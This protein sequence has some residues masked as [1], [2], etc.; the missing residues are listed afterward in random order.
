MPPGVHRIMVDAHAH[1]QPCFDCRKFLEAAHDSFLVYSGQRHE[2][3]RCVGCLML[4]DPRSGNSLFRLQ[5]RVGDE[6]QSGWH[7]MPTEEVGSLLAYR[8]DEL[9]M[10]LVAGR[11][12]VTAE[13]L[14][15][16][17]LGTEDVIDD[18]QPFAETLQAA[19]A[20]EAIP[21]LPWGFGKWRFRR[22]RFLVNFLESLAE[23]PYFEG[24]EIFLGDNGQR[25]A[26]I[27]EPRLLQAARSAGFRI[28]PGSDPLPFP[29][30]LRRPGSY[31]C[32]LNGYFDPARPVSGL[33]ALLAASRSQPERYGQLER[34]PQFLKN[35]LAMQLRK[36][37]P[38][39]R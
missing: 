8:H 39:R 26:L 13:G 15:I 3:E 37:V 7:L 38:H 34:L 22:G 2:Q 11:Q 27:G 14:E 23:P 36:R 32:F 35:Q 9:A 33:K 24:H 4:A 20:A 28:L 17:A 10:V 16:L 1:L 12:L 6:L 29:S 18:Q 25:T 19:V 31:G 30:Q 21:V 5:D